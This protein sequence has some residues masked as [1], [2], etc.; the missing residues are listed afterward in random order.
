VL[1]TARQLGSALGVAIFVAVLGAHPAK[2]LAGFDRA[3]IVVLI[4]AAMTACAGLTTGRQLS[5]VPAAAKAD[6]AADALVTSPAGPGPSG[7]A[8]RIREREC[9]PS[10]Q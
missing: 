6:K 7:S 8:A 4:T 10:G 3:W 2:D 5:H 1:A 9:Q